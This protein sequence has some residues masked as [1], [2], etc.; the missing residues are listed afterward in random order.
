MKA[1]MVASLALVLAVPV[2]AQ[3]WTTEEQAVID[4]IKMCWNAWVDAQREGGPD[5]FFQR[6]P[7]DENSSFWWTDAATP[8]SVER[9]RREWEFF[10]KI[11]LGWVDMRPIVVRIWGDVA[12]VQFYGYWKANTPEGPV[13]TEYM[14]TELFRRNGSHW[15]FLGGQGTPVSA[16]DA[17]PYN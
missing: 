13:T 16:K 2:S 8:Q 4:H 15:V 7:F 5:Q 10:A 11:D 17:A 9:I 14:R 3:Q 12:M 6:C 1:L